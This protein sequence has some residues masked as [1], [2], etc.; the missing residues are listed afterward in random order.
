[1]L[2]NFVFPVNQINKAEIICC[3]DNCNCPD[4]GL[5]T[6]LT[7]VCLLFVSFVRRARQLI[8]PPMAPQPPRYWEC[9]RRELALITQP[10]L[11]A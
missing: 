8:C 4:I 3:L 5:E 9:L 11:L 2:K 7:F 1:M 6:T 10:S